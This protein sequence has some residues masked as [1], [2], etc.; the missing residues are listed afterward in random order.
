MPK[1]ITHALPIM[2]PP[3]RLRQRRTDI[4][5]LQLVT[6]FL[7]LSMRH[8]IRHHH[9]A[10]QA[11]IQRLNRFPAQDPVRHDRDDFLG[12]PV[13]DQ[14]VGG[15]YQS[16]AGV[17]HVVD[18]DGGFPGDGADEDHARYFVRAGAFLV[19]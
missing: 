7:F 16:T 13:V 18:E 14:C 4:N 3:T 10:Q 17:G 8:R 1:Q 19:D 11:P 5:R 2:R 12:V 6:H 9:P 15:F